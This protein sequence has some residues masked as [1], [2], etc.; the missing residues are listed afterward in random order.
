MEK[1]EIHS[2]EF[3]LDYT[4]LNELSYYDSGTDYIDLFKGDNFVG[5]LY[6]YTDVE[7]DKREY[8]CV[9]YEIIYLDGIEKIND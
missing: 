6:V 1:M 5:Y 7:N 2:D 3:F 8:V 4:D 9:N